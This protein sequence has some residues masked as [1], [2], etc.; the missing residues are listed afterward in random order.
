MDFQQLWPG[1][2]VKTRVPVH[3]GRQ[4]KFSQNKLMGDVPVGTLFTVGAIHTVERWT[5]VEAFSLG[6]K[7]KVSAEEMA[8]LFSFA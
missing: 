5:E 8:L 4:W 1:K 2:R 6:L 7:L 3:A